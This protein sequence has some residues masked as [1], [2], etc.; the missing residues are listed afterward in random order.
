MM[1]SQGLQVGKQ[2][3]IL[4]DL[5]RGIVSEAMGP[6]PPPISAD[7]TLLHALET[8]LR[9]DRVTEFPVV[10]GSGRLIGSLSFPKA[11][12]V[13]GSDPTHG[14]QTAMTPRE[15]MR[16]VR[17]DLPLDRAIEWI[18]GGGQALVVDGDRVVGLLSTGDI[19]NWYRRRLTGVTGPSD[20]AP[21]PP[22]P[23]LGGVGDW[24]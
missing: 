7:V 6:A 10:D 16:E 1:I 12:K 11:A 9:A 24:R 21:V 22:R 19:D 20:A 17:P 5:S 2:S 8:H 18:A 23:D 15:R 3:P 4:Q 13:G 14:V